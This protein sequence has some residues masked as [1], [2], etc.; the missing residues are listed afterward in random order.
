MFTFW[1]H[2][3][4]PE[5]I[6]TPLIQPWISSLSPPSPITSQLS[7]LTKEKLEEKMMT[8]VFS[9]PSVSW[10]NEIP[11]PVSSLSLTPIPFQPSWQSASP[12]SA[13]E[14][15][16]QQLSTT[17]PPTSVAL[18]DCSCGGSHGLSAEEHLAYHHGASYREYLAPAVDRLVGAIRPDYVPYVLRKLD[19]AFP[20]VSYCGLSDLRSMP[21]EMKERAVMA[22]NDLFLRHPDA[23]R[24]GSDDTPRPPSGSDT[25]E[26]WFERALTLA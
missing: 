13:P 17:S 21:Y 1:K 4:K 26:E 23:Y 19:E 22:Y 6:S 12:T 10:N 25:A 5:P 2:R 16:A 7:E 15:G 24:P 18:S 20:L 11:L 8:F 14:A 9:H 3:R